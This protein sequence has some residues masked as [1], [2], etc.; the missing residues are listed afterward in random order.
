MERLLGKTLESVTVND[1]KNEIKF[2]TTDGETFVMWHEQDCCEGVYIE[3]ITG[4]LNALI[5]SPILLSEEVS[6]PV[7]EKQFIDNFTQKEDDYYPTNEQGDSKPESHTWTFYKLAT[8]KG[9]V[10]IRWYGESNGYYSESVTFDTLA[11]KENP[12]D[13]D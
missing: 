13:F 7:F 6:N 2:V 1:S 9:Y 3:D 8:I 4:D 10:H 12:Y 11:K 5:G